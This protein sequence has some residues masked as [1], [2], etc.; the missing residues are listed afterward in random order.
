[1][2]R[3]TIRSATSPQNTDVSIRVRAEMLRVGSPSWDFRV[4]D[5]MNG[6]ALYTLAGTVFNTGTAN[7]TRNLHA[8]VRLGRRRVTRRRD[9][10]RR[11]RSST[12]PTTPSQLVL[13]AEPLTAF[14]RCAFTGAPRTCL[15]R[16]RRPARSAR[17]GFSPTSASCSR[18]RRSGHG[19]VRPARHR[20][21]ARPLSRAPLLALRQHRRPARALGP[22]RHAARVRRGVGQRVRGDG[23]RRAVYIDT[24]GAGQ[25]QSFSFD[26]EQRPSR[27]NPNPGW[28][29]EESLQSLIFD[30]YD[31][32]RDVP[33]GSARRRRS[34]ARVRPD[35]ARVHDR[36][37]HD[38]RAD[39][40]VPVRGRAESRAS[41][42]R[43]A[44]R[45]FDDVAAHRRR[46]ATPM[47]RGKRTS[48]CRRSE[49]CS[50]SLSISTRSMSNVAVGATLQNVC[51]LDDYTSALTGAENKLASRRFVRF[52]VTNPG[53]H[54]ITV[55]ARAPLNAA[56]DP[57]LVLHSAAA[58]TL[59][60][61]VAAELLGADAV[62]LRRGILADAVGRRACARGLRMDEHE[63]ARRS[64]SSDRPN[65]LRRDG[66]AMTARA[67]ML[68]ILGV[69]AWPSQGA[70]APPASE[71]SAPLV[72][73]VP[74]SRRGRSAWSTRSRRRRPSACRSRSKSRRASSPT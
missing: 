19:R 48:A 3:A 53:P 54:T 49:R 27:T 44:D 25:R 24:F 51:S 1:M 45:Q 72:P 22:A 5:N 47:A 2:R 33:P 63:C 34:C 16:A 32:G 64:R 50:K 55:R 71:R 21:R 57:D 73:H 37:A 11:S 67:A 36:A 52:T 38:A 39:E 8:R 26:V 58:E 28:F 40:R 31:N 12:S 13:T 6:D 30:L 59:V 14:P 61:E 17:A 62:G 65:V 60:S 35:L 20:A 66:D 7:V 4:V 41:G 29:N 69:L 23:D 10:P 46:H 15:S 18:R 56:A 74:P 43:G 42:G 9:P 70:A 68:L